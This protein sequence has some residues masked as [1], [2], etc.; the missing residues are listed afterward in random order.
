MLLIDKEWTRYL[1]R[2]TNLVPKIE[3]LAINGT[4]V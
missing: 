2:G 3:R 4:E 1:M